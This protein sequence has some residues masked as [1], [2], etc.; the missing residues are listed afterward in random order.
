[1]NRLILP[2]RPGFVCGFVN[3]CEGHPEKRGRGDWHGIHGR[4][5]RLGVRDGDLA[6]SVVIFTSDLPE[7]APDWAR[8]GN[9]SYPDYAGMNVHAAWPW[10]GGV[11]ERL[12][13]KGVSC[14]LLD[15]PC[16]DGPS[17]AL[18]QDFLHVPATAPDDDILGALEAWATGYFPKF[19][20]RR[21]DTRFALCGH[22]NGRG[23]QEKT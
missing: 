9:L 17:W 22:C 23:Y 21:L 13:S 4:E 1:M 16:F 10:E 15:A 20:E 7:N 8:L 12:M 19:R 3:C 6:A 2:G 11:A 14:P 18:V 5:R